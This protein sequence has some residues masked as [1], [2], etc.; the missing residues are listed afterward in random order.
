MPELTRA[1]QPRRPTMHDVAS[2]AAVSIK[3]VSR[4]VNNEPVVA[5]HLV[6][7]V[8]AA[9]AELGFRRNDIARNLRSR[10]VNA[11]IGLLIEEMANPFYAA[12]AS[13]A[14][15]IAATHQT[16]LIVASSEEDPERERELLLDLA[17]RRVDGLLVVPA[18]KDHSFLQRELDMGISMVFLDRPPE[19]LRADAVLLDNQGGTHAGMA[20]LLAAG[21]RR[22]GLLFDSLGVWTMRERLAG[23]AS[24]YQSFGAGIDPTMIRDEVKGPEDAARVVAGMLQSAEPPTAFFCANN[25]LC[26]GALMALH[27]YGSPAPLLGFDDFTLSHLMPRPLTLISY[28]VHELARVGVNRVFSRVHG[29]SSPPTITVLP[30]HLIER[31]LR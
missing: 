2:H 31:G 5:A 10:R 16:L 7:R 24:S 23:V 11:T 14:A 4:V 6:D 3:T 15:E 26:A 17:Q 13:V 9:I 1:A 12:I 19:R 28:D 21:H 8:H 25:Q 29:D 30:T 20:Q 18:G 22:I 27:E